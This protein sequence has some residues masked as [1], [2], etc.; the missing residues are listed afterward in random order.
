MLL[1]CL[2]FTKTSHTCVHESLPL[3]DFGFVGTTFV[4][5]T[6]NG[7]TWKDIQQW[8]CAS[9]CCV[10]G[11][12]LL[13]EHLCCC[14]CCCWGCCY[15]VTPYC[16]AVMQVIEHSVKDP[17]IKNWLDLLCFLLSGLPADGTIAAEVAYMFNEWY[18]PD[19][20]LEFPK[21]GSQAM[22]NALVRYNCKF[23]YIPVCVHIHHNSIFSFRF[24][25]PWKEFRDAIGVFTSFL[26]HG[27]LGEGR[28][29]QEGFLRI[30]VYLW[31]NMHSSHML[32]K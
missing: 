28:R 1:V 29:V 3:C 26:W 18:R 6:I 2:K 9:Y 17:F 25:G 14:C 20:C 32:C 27:V 8:F 23:V 5:V 7:N 12:K 16:A 21:G 11:C 31:W 10:P 13:A 22:V 24:C 4:H 19:C 15:A 30:R